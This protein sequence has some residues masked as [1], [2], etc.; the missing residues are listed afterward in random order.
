[1]AQK[2]IQLV[3]GK[4]TQVEAQVTSAGVADA[5]KIPAL[6]SSGK[7][8][9]SLLPVSIGPDVAVVEADENLSPGDYVNIFDDAGTPKARL[10]DSANARDAHGFVKANVTAGNPATVYFEGA[11]DDLSGLTV[12]A[13]Y[14]LDTAGNATA[15]PPAAPAAQISQFVG[16][17]INSTTINT[18][19]DDCIILA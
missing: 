11:N 19:I 7:L 16:I 12:G 10:A 5:G 4:L 17:A 18:D 14:Y 6:D 13:R 9:L 15:T 3:N 2:P 8:D 1:M